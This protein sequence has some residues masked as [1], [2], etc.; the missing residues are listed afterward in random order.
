MHTSFVDTR[1][2]TYPEIF[3]FLVVSR[4]RVPRIL[5]HL[6]CEESIN[7]RP[8]PHLSLTSPPSPLL[9]E[10]RRTLPGPPEDLLHRKLD[11][12]LATRRQ[13]VHPF[14]PFPVRSV[15]GILCSLSLT[16]R[17]LGFS[18][19]S[20]L[21]RP[22]PLPRFHPPRQSG[23]HGPFGSFST[24]FGV[25]LRPGP[26]PPLKV[27]VYRPLV[28]SASFQILV[29]PRRPARFSESDLHLSPDR[30]QRG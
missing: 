24:S 20:S 6:S 30:D 29:P 16:S 22:V 10:L 8:Y 15:F 9:R 4:I 27:F 13:K 1:S 5:D 28:L 21:F 12:D 7:Y 18:P 23:G 3:L 26:G 25:S 17:L 14:V 11:P 19:Y 2:R